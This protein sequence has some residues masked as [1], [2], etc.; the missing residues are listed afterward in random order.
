MR[1]EGIQ[2]FAGHPLVFRGEVLG[3]MA[4]FSRE[5]ISDQAFKW[6]D[7]AYEERDIWLMNLKVDPVFSRVR[8]NRRFADL[9]VRTGLR[10]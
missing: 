1:R 10:P 3:V 8:Q 5:P 7:K 9:L 4:V 6:L 2:R